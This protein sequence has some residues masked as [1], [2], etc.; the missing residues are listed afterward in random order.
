MKGL[1]PIL[2]TPDWTEFW[3]AAEAEEKIKGFQFAGPGAYFV[4]G[5]TFLVVPSAGLEPSKM[6]GIIWKQKWPK[7]T[8]FGF[9]VWSGADASVTFNAIVNAPIRH[10]DR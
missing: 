9:Y 1:I 8:K 3:T 5:D 10:D 2:V 7:Q 4:K 6:G